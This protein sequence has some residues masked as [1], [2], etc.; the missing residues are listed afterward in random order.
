MQPV[1]TAFADSPD[2]GRGFARDLRVR[3]ALAEV[4]QAYDVRLLSFA[5]MKEAAHR[6]I[7]PFGQIPTFEADGAALFETGAIILH[8]A[9]RHA[10]LLPADSSARARVVS[11]MFAAVGTV[12]PAVVE[13]EMAGHAERDCAWYG[14]RLTI[15]DDRIR[16]KLNDLSA[17]LGL[18]DWLVDDFSA[19]D[20]LMIDALRRLH[21]S[22]LLSEFPSLVSYVARGEER[23]AFRAAFDAQ[24]AVYQAKLAAEAGPD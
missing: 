3:W 22:D 11:W 19:A 18:S 16:R 5:E 12:E 10:G 23:P 7:H 8:I 24:L 17:A 20:V 15:M 6:A 1:I 4:G 9:E 14:D 21:D 2:R 13:R